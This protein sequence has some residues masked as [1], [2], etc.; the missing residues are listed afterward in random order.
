MWP[1][2]HAV[3]NGHLYLNPRY[4]LRRYPGGV[5]A[6]QGKVGQLAHS[7]GALIFLLEGGISSGPGVHGQSFKG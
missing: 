7:N 5:S 6:Q 2:N 3:N 4:L 1:H